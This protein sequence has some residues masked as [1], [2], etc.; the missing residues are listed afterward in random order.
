MILTPSLLPAQEVKVHGYFM[1]D[2]A[3]LGERVAYVLKAEYSLGVDILFPDSLYSFG[4]M[5]FLEKQ[6]FRSFTKDSVTQDS[7]IYYLSNFSLEPVKRYH[8]PVFEILRYDSI[9]HRPQ[10]AELFLHLV[11]DELPDVLAFQET[12]AYQSMR[13]ALDYP[14]LIL[15]AVLFG[16]LL[17][18]GYYFFGERIKNEWLVYRERKRRKRFLTRWETAQQVFFADKNLQAAD[19][20]LGLWR[21]Y[22]ESLTGKPFREW[23]ATEI[24]DSLNQPTLVNDL[25][26][27]EMVIYA[28]RV[29][30]RIKE[31][32][33]RLSLL[34]E[35]VF[36]AK[37]KNLHNHE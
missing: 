20:L 21:G 37:I 27:I 25:R 1:Q 11:I 4:S 5:E 23:T 8:L 13:G 19:E 31:S 2:S 6:T 15:I 30:D 35:D 33:D 28:N 12:N 7:A 26:E 18:A 17:L 9:I 16:V 24:A 14:F 3:K 36:S 22:M 34:S 10:D 32:C 29:T